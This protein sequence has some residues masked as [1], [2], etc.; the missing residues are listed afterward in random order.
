MAGV[1]STD[2][3][4]G[5][6]GEATTGRPALGAKAA[7]LA[8]ALALGLAS[9]AA[10]SSGGSKSAA[11]STTS[12]ASTTPPKGETGFDPKSFD[13]ANPPGETR[14]PVTLTLTTPPPVGVP[15]TLR[16]R[17]APNVVPRTASGPVRLTGSTTAGWHTINRGSSKPSAGTARTYPGGTRQEWDADAP[18][19]G[20]T[21]YGPDGSI[22]TVYP[23]GTLT[24]L[25]TDGYSESA[26]MD[27]PFAP[28]D[29]YDEYSSDGGHTHIGPDGIYSKDADGT[30]HIADDGDGAV[31]IPPLTYGPADPPGK[32]PSGGVGEP[33]YLTED[34]ESLTTQRLGE[35]VLT[36][37]VS[38]QEVQARTQPWKDSTSAAAMT[39]LAFGV[40]G[41]KVTV[42]ISGTVR[43]DG[44]TAPDGTDMEFGFDHGGEV[45]LWR[46][47]ASGPASD[48]VVVWPDLSVAW[49]KVHDGWLDLRLQWR[50]ATGQRRG[51]LG[52][53][54]SNPAND[55]TGRDGTLAVAADHSSVDAMVRSWQVTEAESL[56]D[57][58][59]GKSTATYR[60]DDFPREQP[61]PAPGGSEK[62]CA[63]VPAGFARDACEYDVAL[64]GATV[65]VAPA[66]QFGLVVNGDAARRRAS[67]AVAKAAK[68]LA[69]AARPSTTTTKPTTSTPG[70]QGGALVLTDSDRSTAR[71]TDDADGSVQ[72]DLKAGQSVTYRLEIT[73]RSS[74]YAL[75]GDLSCPGGKFSSKTGGYAYFDDSG[76]AVVGPEPACDD[77]AHAV[78]EAGNYY[79]K[80]VGPGS[81]DLDL[82][83]AP[84]G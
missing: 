17:S 68:D 12:V 51:L 46:D 16:L 42:D 8:G 84:P 19:S 43:I 49:I 32:K 29:T 72:D 62:A 56:F 81:F 74:I 66:R 27:G 7:R 58:D 38:G 36:T 45:G 50:D 24:H 14:P 3:G 48:I 2:E 30:M 40:D 83:V 39:A 54:D 21:T 59:T 53:D 20:V 13:P 9:L 26:G 22:D 69:S 67:A 57:Y 25:G 70:A 76:K 1:G 71:L 78:V 34:G 77:S 31:D 4:N 33:H 63:G 79:L 75:N 5:N 82:N 18:D 23:D 28:G 10:C 47:S 35:F 73:E 65:W 6:P 61:N 80:L 41:Q 11:P 44:K 37:G 55:L 15:S 64:T 52:S 60:I